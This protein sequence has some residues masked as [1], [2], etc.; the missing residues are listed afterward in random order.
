[1]N[2]CDMTPQQIVLFAT[3]ISSLVSEDCSP[4]EM[5][6]L[7]E[8]FRMVS[9][10]LFNMSKITYLQEKVCKDCRKKDC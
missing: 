10:N 2:L 8:I 6:I 3:A 1:M 4:D 5:C 7:A 9:E